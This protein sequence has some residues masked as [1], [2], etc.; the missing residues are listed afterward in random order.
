MNSFRALALS[1]VVVAVV[2]A[3]AA[4]NETEVRAAL[5][6]YVESFNRQDIAAVA[7]AWTEQASHTDRETGE[8]TEGREAIQSDI[9]ASFKEQPNA[10]L[11]GRVDRVRMIKPDV[12][13]VEGETTFGAGDEAPVV[14]NFAAILV[15]QGDKW[16]IDSIEELPLPTPATSTEALQDLE[17]MIGSWLDDGG[18][19]RVTTQVRWTASNAF[20]LRSFTI[21]SADGTQQGTQ[22]IGWDPRSQEIRSWSFNSDGSF[23]D[24]VWTQSG[25]DWLIKS[26][27]T[28]SDGRAASGTYVLKR[29]DDNTITL[30]LIGHEID[31]EP[32]PA[33]EAVKMARAPMLGAPTAPAGLPTK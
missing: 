4:A 6:A 18:E 15:K 17:W 30:E 27:Q 22:V 19:S 33:K 8:R 21:E 20:L 12:A 25:E 28:L 1:F 23:G 7:A 29:L 32:Q 16:L 14:N 26:S 13:S 9:A 24:G 11:A 2:A 3:N 31:G 5:T 10:H